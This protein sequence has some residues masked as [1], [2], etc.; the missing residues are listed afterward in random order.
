MSS[1]I[2]LSGTRRSFFFKSAITV[3]FSFLCARLVQREIHL[4]VVVLRLYA[5]NDRL[6][7]REVEGRKKIQKLLGLSFWGLN[8]FI[9]L[10]LIVLQVAELTQ[11]VEHE[12]TY[13]VRT[14]GDPTLVQVSPK[15]GATADK[16][17]RPQQDILAPTTSSR[18]AS[19][20]SVQVSKL[21]LTVEALQAQL[22]DQTRL[23]KEQVCLF[24][25]IASV[26]AYRCHVHTRISLIYA[27]M[28]AF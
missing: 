20:A 7:I 13:V 25:G 11:P 19:E 28:D 14:P 3:G 9:E 4:F 22:E 12:T 5:E 1:S 8:S 2:R 17:T 6:R 27:C 26:H 18:A 21:V 23:A 24:L 15:H 10:I 16:N